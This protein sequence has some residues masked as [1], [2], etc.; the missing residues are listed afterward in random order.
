M[1]MQVVSEEIKTTALTE[2]N[3]DQLIGMLSK[4]ATTGSIVH[5]LFRSR[6]LKVWMKRF[7]GGKIEEE[8]MN[9]LGVNNKRIIQQI[10]ETCDLAIRVFQISIQVHGQHY[11]R[12]FS[13]IVKMQG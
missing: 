8:D 13:E 11:N 7:S 1:I 10:K 9:G 2:E 3:Q 4:D 12:I 5:T 6:I